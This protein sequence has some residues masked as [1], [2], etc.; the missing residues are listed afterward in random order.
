MHKWIYFVLGLSLI[1]S[2]VCQSSEN[3]QY[4]IINTTA[5]NLREKPSHKSEL[6]DQEIMGYSV[7]LLNKKDNWHLVETEYGYKGWTTESSFYAVDCNELEAWKKCPKVRV[8][9]VLATVYSQP[10]EKSVPVASVGMNTLLKN[11]EVKFGSWIKTALP[12]GRIGYIK[13][14]DCVDYVKIKL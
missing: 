9:A 13:K 10:K 3:K 1:L 12:D 6:L 7:K 14:K 11:M 8:K 4:A 2:A 5:A